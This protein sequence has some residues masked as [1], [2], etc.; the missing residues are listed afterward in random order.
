MPRITVRRGALDPG[1]RALSI[2]CAT[3][4]LASRAPAL[5]E[6]DAPR[7]SGHLAHPSRRIDGVRGA[8]L[9]AIL[10]KT[11]SLSLFRSRRTFSDLRAPA[12]LSAMRG[13]KNPWYTLKADDGNRIIK[14]RKHELR[15]LKSQISPRRRQPKRGAQTEAA[16]S[17]SEEKEEDDAVEWLDVALRARLPGVPGFCEGKVI[18]HQEQETYLVEW[19]YP[20]PLSGEPV[21][22]RQSAGV[23]EMRKWKKPPA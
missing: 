22:F 11:P 20:N 23:R 2:T 8:R 18:E 4:R 15:L 13:G 6:G 14:F 5:R 17:D 9:A 3:V 7:R 10:E 1:P 16:G 19:S 12:A 21:T